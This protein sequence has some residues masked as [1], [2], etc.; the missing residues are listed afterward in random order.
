MSRAFLYVWDLMKSDCDCLLKE[1][2]PSWV[3]EAEEQHMAQDPYDVYYWDD[4]KMIDEVAQ[5][6]G[7]N[8]HASVW[9]WMQGPGKAKVADEI[10]RVR[11]RM[12]RWG[13]KMKPVPEW[14]SIMEMERV[15]ATDWE[16]M[17]TEAAGSISDVSKVGLASGTPTA[18]CNVGGPQCG[19]CYAKNSEQRNNVMIPLMQHLR[20]LGEN[21]M[22]HASAMQYLLGKQGGTFRGNWSGDYQGVPH[23]A[24]ALSIAAGTP[25][26]KHWL[27]TKEAPAML[28]YLSQFSPE[29]MRNAI[30][31]NVGIR[32]SPPHNRM[33]WGPEGGGVVG[34]ETGVGGKWAKLR[35][36]VQTHG[37]EDLIGFSETGTE[38]REDTFTCPVAL[39]MKD[40]ITGEKLGGCSDFGCEFC[41]SNTGQIVQFPAHHAGKANVRMADRRGNKQPAMTPEQLAHQK[42]IAMAMRQMHQGQKENVDL[43]SI[44]P[45]L[46]PNYWGAQ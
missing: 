23:I 44:D 8:P 19:I 6:Y 9:K 20:M 37:L 13:T 22:R 31:S 41:Q 35:D 4:P 32:V 17:A 26:V 25:N 29:E 12:G 33:T 24:Q 45:M 27:H 14:S 18:A 46:D 15:P 43:S 42:A 38:P 28:E 40:P 7:W 36:L 30:P 1:F 2:D 39:Q 34:D 16:K 11:E 5:R 3:Q 21:P 10:Q